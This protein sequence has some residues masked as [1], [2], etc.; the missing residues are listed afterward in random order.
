MRVENL[1][2]EVNGDLIRVAAD[3]IWED[4]SQKRRE[5]YFE[6]TQ[7]F[8]NDLVCNPNA[9]I[10]G[11]ILPAMHFG[12][13]RITI[14]EGICPILKEGLMTNMAWYRYWYGQKYKPVS[15]EADASVKPYLSSRLPKGNGLF[16][17]GG[18]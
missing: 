16:L 9:F 8:A 11:C 3:C 13:K 14:K 12:E 4:C 10:V 7:A 6:T 18:V 1:R 15:I 2:K 17:S 5:V